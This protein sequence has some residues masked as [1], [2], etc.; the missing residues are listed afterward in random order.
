MK[1]R[2]LLIVLVLSVLTTACSLPFLGKKENPIP[3]TPT[4]DNGLELY[5]GNGMQI[6][7]PRSYVAEDIDSAL[8]SI[9]AA[10]KNFI[11]GES[12]PLAGLVDSLEGNIG[13]Y[14]YDS[15]KAAVYPTR[16]VIL[17]NKTLAKLPI[18]MVTMG[19]EKMLG[20]QSALVDSDDIRLGGRDVTRLTYSKDDVAWAAY[21]FKEGDH[22][23]MALYVTTPANLAAEL[24]DYGLSVSTI[25]I[26]PVQPAP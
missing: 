5:Y 23:W 10:I 6:M 11:G 8:P 4:P 22:L 16:L 9:V 18:S 26:D 21:L 14:G 1:T 17:R 25:K 3:P 2:I 19:I 13:W 12:S 15:D 20:S 7:L 24:E